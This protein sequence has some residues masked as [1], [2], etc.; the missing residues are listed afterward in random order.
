V[1]WVRAGAT[2]KLINGG[3][4]TDVVFSDSAAPDI[5]TLTN[6]EQLV[7]VGT[8]G[9]DTLTPSGTV[10]GMAFTHV[11]GREGAD[12]IDV[13]NGSLGLLYS[14]EDLD[15]SADSIVNFGVGSTGDVLVFDDD[16]LTGTDVYVSSSN[17]TDTNTGVVVYQNYMTGGTLPDDASDV[18]IHLVG[19]GFWDLDTNDKMIFVVGTNTESHVWYWNDTSGDG[20]MEAAELTHVASID[21]DVGA[22]TTD[23]ISISTDD[24]LFQYQE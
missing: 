11:W 21:Q 9:A 12:T 5:T 13:S 23:N 18:S 22:I 20:F 8:S 3:T 6:V 7:R 14:D 4:G 16:I 17:T 24:D 15:G 1:F 2:I 19:A 10:G